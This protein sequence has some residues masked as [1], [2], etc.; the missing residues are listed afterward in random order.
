[1]HSI[2]WAAGL[3]EGEGCI[4]ASNKR[5]CLSMSD[6]D[7]VDSFESVFPGGRRYVESPRSERHKPMYKYFINKK[8]LIITYLSQMLPFFHDRR[9]YKALNILDDLELA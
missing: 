6:K 5:L 3:F 9:A 8:N 4:D 7:V 2:E 1:M